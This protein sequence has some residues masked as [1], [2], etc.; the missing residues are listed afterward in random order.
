MPDYVDILSRLVTLFTV[1]KIEDKKSLKLIVN[2]V[3]DE[4]LKWLM[5][6]ENYDYT[7]FECK[8]LEWCSQKVLNSI[9]SNQAI[10]QKILEIYR[11]QYRLR[12]TTSGVNDIIVQ[13]FLV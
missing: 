6:M 8:W 5:D 12:K 2:R 13:Y 1:G 9:T 11:E 7:L 3:G 4:R 10:R